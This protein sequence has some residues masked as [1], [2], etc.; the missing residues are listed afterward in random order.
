MTVDASKRTV[1][2]NIQYSQSTMSQPK[3]PSTTSEK[4]TNASKLIPVLNVGKIR[5]RSTYVVNQSA[6][7]EFQEISQLAQMN[8]QLNALTLRQKILKI[9]RMVINITILPPSILDKC[10]QLISPKY[11]SISNKIKSFLD[12]K[13]AKTIEAALTDTKR[14]TIHFIDNTSVTKN[15]L[16]IKLK[17]IVSGNKLTPIEKYRLLSFCFQSSEAL[18]GD[19]YFL[20]G[21]T[22][23]TPDIPLEKRMTKIDI[24]TNTKI[25]TVTRLTKIKCLNID[26]DQVDGDKNYYYRDT[27][28]YNYSE[29][30]YSIDRTALPVSLS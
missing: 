21:F 23:S 16:K 13:L 19:E 1:N 25:M 3:P 10:S 20:K 2:P 28:V 9:L 11:D 27:L 7:E 14:D 18:I 6:T 26:G 12:F 29:N 15:D 30:K 8:K 5:S 17:E 24:D 4:V 22:A